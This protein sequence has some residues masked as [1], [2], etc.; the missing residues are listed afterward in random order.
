V[1]ALAAASQCVD[2]L[3][4]SQRDV[5]LAITSHVVT[6]WQHVTLNET[7]TSEE[8]SV[9]GSQWMERFVS[10]LCSISAPLACHMNNSQL[11]KVCSL[12][13]PGVSIVTY[14]NQ[15]ISDPAHNTVQSPY[16]LFLINPSSS[17][18]IKCMSLQNII[19][20][21]RTY[22]VLPEQQHLYLIIF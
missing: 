16:S 18:D 3:S 7:L 6:L 20:F 1:D 14:V 13:Y 15:T 19:C 21:H 8:T 10:V 22:A 11:I 4:P 5:L 9:K 12:S 2:M 17:S